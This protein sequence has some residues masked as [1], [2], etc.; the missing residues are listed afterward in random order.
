MNSLIESLGA[1]FLAEW[2]VRSRVDQASL[3][4]TMMIEVDGRLE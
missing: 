3:W 4:K 2:M 1:V